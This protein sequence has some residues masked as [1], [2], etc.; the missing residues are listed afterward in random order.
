MRALGGTRQSQFA[1]LRR[2]MRDK[3]YQ[4]LGA[5]E[6]VPAF[7]P[8]A[9]PQPPTKPATKHQGWSIKM[10]QPGSSAALSRL[11]KTAAAV[12]AAQEEAAMAP[13]SSAPGG[14]SC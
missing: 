4:K 3:A 7:K 12:A 9:D 2:I 6:P 10:V 13:A 8:P 14:E 1:V 11:A 5:F